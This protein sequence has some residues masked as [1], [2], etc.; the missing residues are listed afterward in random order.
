MGIVDSVV[1]GINFP[2]KLGLDL[3]KRIESDQNI[4]NTLWLVAPFS[5]SVDLYFLPKCWKVEKCGVCGPIDL[6]LLHLI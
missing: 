1:C 5:L 2:G 4:G 3:P 6:P